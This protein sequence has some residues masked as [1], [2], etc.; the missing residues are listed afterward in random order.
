MYENQAYEHAG[1]CRS[2]LDASLQAELAASD[3]IA[4]V[5]ARR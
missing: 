2:P 4:R 3:L 5:R 1:L